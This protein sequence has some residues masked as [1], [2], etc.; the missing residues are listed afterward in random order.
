MEGHMITAT[1]FFYFKKISIAKLQSHILT[2]S[3]FTM[4]VMLAI[5]RRQRI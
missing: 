4:L 3:W 2:P 5:Y 1:Q